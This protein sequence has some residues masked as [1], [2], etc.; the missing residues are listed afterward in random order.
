MGVVDGQGRKAPGSGLSYNILQPFSMPH[1]YSWPS[2]NALMN[3]HELGYPLK[4]NRFL[5]TIEQGLFWPIRPIPFQRSS[6]ISHPL[7]ISFETGLKSAVQSM[8]PLEP[9]RS[10]PVASCKPRSPSTTNP[11]LCTTSLSLPRRYM[12]LYILDDGHMNMDR[13]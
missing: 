3:L 7:Q 1:H 4:V 5:E 11:V 13:S 10:M 8:P 2:W 6:L 12:H 9:E